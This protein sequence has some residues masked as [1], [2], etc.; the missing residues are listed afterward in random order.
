M[1]SHPIT[2]S[3]RPFGVFAKQNLHG[4]IA[5]HLGTKIVS[6][7]HVAGEILPTEASLGASLGVSRTAI[8]EAIKVLSSKGLV[9]VRR[10]TGSRV[11]SQ[12]DW[13][14][15][16]PDVISWQFAG[17]GIPTGA[18][19]DLTELRRII[20]PACARLAA[21]RATA[22]ELAEIEKAL[23]EMEQAA[24]K[25]EASVEADLNFHLAILEA[26]HNSF[27]R[28]FGALIQ[29]ALRAS[30]RLTNADMA[31]Y[32]LSLTKHRAVL[33]SIKNGKPEEADIAMQI[34]L[35]GSQRDLEH[36][37]RPPAPSRASGQEKKRSNGRKRS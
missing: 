25:T 27:M 23:I 7:K 20:E 3:P 36:A 21:K 37:L 14:A 17:D 22:E 13:N 6:G 5:D 10:K 33:A 31:A 8:R 18:I 16:D 32:R 11:R 1:V 34:V 19:N 28:P 2:K 4:Q 24:G 15:L 35:R 30:F 12:R 9:E 26:T 29:A